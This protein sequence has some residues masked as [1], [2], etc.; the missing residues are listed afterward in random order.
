MKLSP[1]ISIHLKQGKKILDFKIC[2][3]ESYQPNTLS[4]SSHKNILSM[5]LTSH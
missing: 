1:N 2:Y 5:L 4:V 3:L